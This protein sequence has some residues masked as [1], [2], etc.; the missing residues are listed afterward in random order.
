[1]HV[2]TGPD[3]YNGKDVYRRDEI[4]TIVSDTGS[5]N[6]TATIGNTLYSDATLFPI[7]AKVTFNFPDE[8]GSV[9]PQVQVMEINY[10]QKTVETKFSPGMTVTSPDGSKVNSLSQPY[11]KNEKANLRNGTRYLYGMWKCTP[12]I[13]DVQ[14]RYVRQHISASPK[15]SDSHNNVSFNYSEATA[16]F[17]V[18]RHEKLKL[19]GKTYDAL[20][21]LE[22]AG[23][24]HRITWMTANG[25]VLK[26]Q[27]CGTSAT[28]VREP[29]GKAEDVNSQCPE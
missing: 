16:D 26:S 14:V 28:L 9:T 17:Q 23:S 7:K 21:V 19:D 25:D 22:S 18:I 13:K 6:S 20:L 11:I 10:T 12:D 1:M 29:K 4:V 15:S 2:T 8:N 5:P 24:D 27:F 3:K